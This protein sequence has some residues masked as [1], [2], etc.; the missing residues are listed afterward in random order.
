VR[1]IFAGTPPFAAQALEALAQAGHDIPLVLTQPDRPAGRGLRLT[2]SAV[3]SRADALKLP[4]G[5]PVSLRDAQAEALVRDADADVMV[6]AAYGLILPPSVLALPRRGC[7]NIHASLLPRWR[8]A[9][10]VQRAILAGDAST[11]ITIMRMDAGLDTGPMLLARPLPIDPRDTTGTLT[12]KLAKLG[13]EAVVDAL[14]RL[15]S[16]A[17]TPQDDAL[18]TYAAKVSKAEARLDWSHHAESLARRVRAF[19][20]S[21]GAEARVGH[22]ALKVWEAESAPLEN[23]AHP[24]GTVIAGFGDLRVACGEGA[25]RLLV[26][27]R[28]GA[29]RLPAAEFLK[30]R[31]ILAFA[32]KSQAID[33]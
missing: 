30:N 18:A 13:A 6:V 10:P 22:E 14:S 2:A 24:P 8:G 12:E 11:G 23:G 1:L 20:P 16:L 4:L 25:L 9:A 7:I 15:D 27:Q 21:P 5:K 31:P 19:N 28:P 32:P 3:A 33:P 17:G 26:V 29:R